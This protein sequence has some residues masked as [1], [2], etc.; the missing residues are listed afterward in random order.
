VETARVPNIIFR[1]SG[2]F[3]TEQVFET[4]CILELR[5]STGTASPSRGAH[6]NP[7]AGGVKYCQPEY[8]QHCNFTVRITLLVY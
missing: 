6:K 1:K 4:L 5:L 7:K 2:P 3:Q 8:A